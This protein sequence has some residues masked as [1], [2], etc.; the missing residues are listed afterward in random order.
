[1]HNSNSLDGLASALSH[2]MR[3]DAPESVEVVRK[4]ITKGGKRYDQGI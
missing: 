4:F 3:I 1:M 2:A